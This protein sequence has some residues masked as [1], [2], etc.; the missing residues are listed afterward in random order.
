MFGRWSVYFVSCLL[1][2]QSLQATPSTNPEVLKRRGIPEASAHANGLRIDLDAPLGGWT[3]SQML[4]V[5]GKCPSPAVDPVLLSLNGQRAYIRLENGEFQRSFPIARGKNTVRVTCQ[6]DKGSVSATRTIFAQ[7]SPIPLKVLLTSDTDGV[8]TDL[9][10]YE[11]DGSHVYWADEHSP[12]G[13]LFFLNKEGDSF[14]KP[15]YGPYIYTHPS[16]PIGVFKIEAHYWP[17]GAIR[18]TLATLDIVLNEGTA[19]EQRRR[20]RRP[21][22][23]PGLKQVM[24]YIQFFGNNQPPKIWVPEQDPIQNAPPLPK[25]AASNIKPWDSESVQAFRVAVSNLALEQSRRISSRWDPKQ[26]D[27]AGLVRFAYREALSPRSPEQ[28]K[29]LGLPRSM[30]F[31]QVARQVRE[32]FPW[33]PWLWQVKTSHNSWGP[34]A[35]A[36]TLLNYNFVLKSRTLQNLKPADILAFYRGDDQASPWHLMLYAG[37]RPGQE[38]VVYH[39]GADSLRADVRV[40]R[41]TELQSSAFPEWRADPKNPSFLGVYEWKSLAESA[42]AS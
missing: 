16:P 36:G 39:N 26:R 37:G 1:L 38:V 30:A 40:V 27:C 8:Y 29:S 11:P 9:H 21:L 32:N 15:G 25:T 24:A 31:P 10:I 23:A 14:D 42:Q 20:V 22:S 2:Q 28:L 17:G 12:S 18:P 35:D 7:S 19:S 6:N 41:L 4:L 5:K 3:S 33:F 34:F 13:G